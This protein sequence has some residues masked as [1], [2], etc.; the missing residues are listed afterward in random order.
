MHHDAITGTSKQLVVNDY[1]QRMENA[2]T[3]I[4]ELYV[5]LLQE[6]FGLPARQEDETTPFFKY[7]NQS[8]P[9]KIIE[10]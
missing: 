6:K 4:E 9:A 3:L 2:G 5:D 7:Y 1:V 8:S 10:E